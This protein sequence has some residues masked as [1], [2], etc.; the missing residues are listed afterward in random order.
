[1]SQ[2]H[3]SKKVWGWLASIVGVSLLLGAC[4]QWI[5]Q[6][7]NF[8]M[9]FMAG[10]LLIFL[11]SSALFL[12]W[13]VAG[14]SR[15]LAWLMVAAFLI[16]L[17]LGVF[18]AWG[19]PRFGYE[20]KTQQAGYVFEDAY[21]RDNEAWTL[22][23]SDEPLTVAFSDAYGTDQYGGM[24]AL[25]ALIYR[26]ISSDIHRPIL[27][28]VLAAGVMA[29]S[30][31]FFYM[32][33]RRR[34]G[35]QIAII[36]SLILAF[37]PEGVLLGSSQMREPFYIFFLT[38]IFWAGTLGLEQAKRKWV[39]PAAILS[40]AG[41]LLFSFRIALPV[42]GAILFWVWFVIAGRTRKRWLKIVGWG[43]LVL[44]GGMIFL[45]FRD[46][47][48]AVIHWDTLETI[49]RS[50][51]LQFQ[52]EGIPE[53]LHYPLVTVYGLFQP[54]LPA[55][56]AAPAPCLWKGI[57]IFRSLGWY[58]VIPLLLYVFIRLWK[59]EPEKKRWLIAMAV[60]VGVWVLIA[61]MR[62]GGDQWDNPRY[63]TIF[64]P[65][66]AILC[67]WGIRFAR[68]TKD[69]WLTRILVV[70]GIFLAFFTEWYLSRYLS[71][72]LRLDLPVMI[73]LILI[74]SVAVV[75]G[76]MLRDRAHSKTS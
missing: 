54:V 59:N 5:L 33:V 73:L 60:V 64:L 51:M 52:L 20:E 46:W 57:G 44:V 41:L 25:S 38:V 7:G 29:L 6:I 3:W 31:P 75:V 10:S 39:I 12:S 18:L 61:S 13:K 11:I 63:R 30:L 36:S 37:Y 50:G 74:L 14:G 70:E 43:V 32:T 21:R 72:A 45:F 26:S 56:I 62:A 42:F 67:G 71:S 24:L 65:W 35:L 28:V 4:V 1:M 27:I 19:L 16:R 55:A 58:C 34:F 2:K 23:Q 66:V 53:S 76:G 48:D 40:A 69:R 17:I 49:R 15:V 8:W 9:G 22:A 47:V 68:E